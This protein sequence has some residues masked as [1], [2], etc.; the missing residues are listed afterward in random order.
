MVPPAAV[1]ANSTKFR[2]AIWHR[3]KYEMN[4]VLGLSK[5]AIFRARF[6]AMPMDSL[7]I[8]TP[9]GTPVVPE[10][11]T[12]VARSSFLGRMGSMQSDCSFIILSQE[13]PVVQALSGV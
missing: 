5:C 11:Y 13:T 10:V 8:M 12:M 7:V 6:S 1:L 3:G 9:F 4:R 2:S